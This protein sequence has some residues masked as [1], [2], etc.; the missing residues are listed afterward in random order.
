MVCLTLTLTL[1]LTSN[2]DMFSVNR[3]SV[4][5]GD[6][7][8]ILKWVISYLDPTKAG[9]LTHLQRDGGPIHIVYQDFDWSLNS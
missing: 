4:D 7:K 1:T 8:E 2:T 5:F 9:L 6:E 3:Y